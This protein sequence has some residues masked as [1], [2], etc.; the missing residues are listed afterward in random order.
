LRA[1]SLGQILRRTQKRW[2]YQIAFGKAPQTTRILDLVRRPVP[3]R[4]PISISQ[5]RSYSCP[6]KSMDVSWKFFANPTKAQSISCETFD[7]SSQYLHSDPKK[8]KMEDEL[9]RNFKI[10]L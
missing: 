8:I 10:P 4:R 6:K 7:Y 2:N 1:L 9:L 3:K 5:T